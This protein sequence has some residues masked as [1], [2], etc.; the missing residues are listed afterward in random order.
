MVGWQWRASSGL[1][2]FANFTLHLLLH[3]CSRFQPSHNSN[4]N[5]VCKLQ[6]PGEGPTC[7]FSGVAANCCCWWWAAARAE[8][9]RGRLW[10][11]CHSPCYQIR[12]FS[13]NDVSEFHYFYTPPCHKKSDTPFPPDSR[14]SRHTNLGYHFERPIK[15]AD[16]RGSVF[17]SEYLSGVG[18]FWELGRGKASSIKT[19]FIYQVSRT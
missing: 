9:S 16:T 6:G 4:L 3:K 11:Y 17:L 12:G 1:V 14:M 18:G 8:I 7:V 2:A 5:A 13:I 19:N 15:S 10:N